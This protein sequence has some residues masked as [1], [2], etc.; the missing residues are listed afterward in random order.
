MGISHAQITELKTAI[1]DTL[2]PEL[3]QIVTMM[4]MDGD[5][6]PFVIIPTSKDVDLTPAEVSR[7]VALSSNAFV[8]AS[9]NSGV[10]G[11]ILKLAQGD[12]KK[13]LKG[14]KAEGKNPQEREANALAAAAVEFD[15]L[16]TVE[17]LVELAKGT[18]NAA[19]VASESSRKILDKTSNMVMGN[20]REERG[21][22]S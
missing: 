12:Y 4:T 9:Y 19:R 18:E 14:S 16:T 22:N 7:L 10:A 13:K 11:A 8:R 3:A 17:A 5:A 6:S 1:T 21:W 15:I 20:A 2:G